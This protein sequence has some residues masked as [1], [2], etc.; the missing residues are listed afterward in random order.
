M[1]AVFLKLLQKLFDIREGEYER[2]LLMQFN[3][4]LII[5]TLL[6]V[7][8]TVNGLFLAQLGAE[9]LPLAYLLV[10]VFAILV[11]SIYSRILGRINLSRIILATLTVSVLFF[12]LFGILLRKHF[13]SGW[14]LYAF[15][16]VV[17]IFAVLSASQF[18]VLANVVFNARQAKRIFGFIGAGAI[19]GGIVGGYLTTLLAEPIGSENLIFVAA[20]IL[21]L[22]IPNTFYIWKKFVLSTQSKFQ[23]R[24]K[25]PKIE[26]PFFL[27]RKSAHLT[28][29]S[30]IIAISVIVAKLVDFQFGAITSSIIKDPDELTAFFG[31]WFSN[32]NVI[33]L[34]IQL[35]LTRRI[36]N[37]I[38]IGGSLFLLPASIF[39]GAT[40]VLFLPVLWTAVFLK[41]SDASLK[42]S[43]NRATFEL[44]AVPVPSEI[45][46]QAKIFIDVV[47]DSLA[48]GVGGIILIFVINSLELSNEF[49]SI[50]ILA[51]LGLWFYYGKKVRETYKE[52]FKRN[53]KN[54]PPEELLVIN[55]E[56]ESLSGELRYFLRNGSQNQKL[57]ILN[58]LKIQPDRRFAD[59]LKILL[60]DPSPVV[61]EEAIRNLYLLHTE[62]L[63]RSLSALLQ[64]ESLSVR[65]AVFS[66]LISRAGR[67]APTLIRRYLEIKD[68]RIRLP[69]LVSLGEE[70]IDSPILAHRFKLAD[71]LISEFNSL[72]EHPDHLRKIY[73]CHLLKAAGSSRRSLLYTHIEHFMTDQDEEI[74][75][76]AIEAAGK[77]MDPYFIPALIELL[78]EKRTT[79][80][81]VEALVDYGNEIIPAIIRYMKPARVS[82]D[83]VRNIPWVLADFPLQ[84]SVDFLF[85]LSR[86]PDHQTS[87]HALTALMKIKRNRPSL[88]FYRKKC[89]RFFREEYQN[90]SDLIAC[91]F[92]L[93]ENMT[94]F[95]TNNSSQRHKILD[96]LQGLFKEHRSRSY[97]RAGKWLFLMSATVKITPENMTGRV[98]WEQAESLDLHDI[99]NSPEKSMLLNMQNYL[100]EIP[101]KKIG[102]KAFSS[103]VFNLEM[104]LEFLAGLGDD[105]N[106]ISKELSHSILSSS[107]RQ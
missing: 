31:L 62:D 47:V 5:A 93:K 74:R 12:I 8:P 100:S 81:T 103:R 101:L 75:S 59:E 80:R 90:Y 14:I 22:C 63:S 66:Y 19:G 104:A 105:A 20:G 102:L 88:N 21:A 73:T 10:A 46:N 28:Y 91:D 85:T 83:I 37:K 17:A 52:A 86:N 15:Y 78:G 70:S 53:L 24:K 58:Q 94:R 82:L 69:L 23:R 40:L 34:V 54:L 25:I 50:I 77:T 51:L 1:R 39:V 97:S 49:V 79:A 64:S 16:I 9:K 60:K 84:L 96:A 72:N 67:S 95:L 18:W 7:K 33:S 6:I 106:E 55:L 3:F 35:I 32:F 38:G 71:R 45:K 29:L 42:Q 65:T 99:P 92:F 26:H 27:I 57:S 43:L 87:L 98:L 107:D 44:L 89:L 68:Y 11:S 13:V 36:V 56:N 48:T 2:A 41:S 30:A 76:A 61:Q 4:F